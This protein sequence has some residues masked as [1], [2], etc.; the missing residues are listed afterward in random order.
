[1]YGYFATHEAR[2]W[3][4]KEILNV[5]TFFNSTLSFITLFFADVVLE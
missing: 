1:M 2:Y 5:L 4:K 3:L